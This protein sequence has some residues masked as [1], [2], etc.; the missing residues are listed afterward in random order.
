MGG[1]FDPGIGLFYY[2]LLIDDVGDPTEAWDG[3]AED[4][5]CGAGAVGP[6][7]PFFLVCEEGEGQTVVFL[8]SPEASG[9]WLQGN[10]GRGF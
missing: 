8:E 6:A 10:A 2:P 9:V 3:L 5:L 1:R 4:F 7:Y